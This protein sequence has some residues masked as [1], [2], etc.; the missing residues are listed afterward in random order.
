MFFIV[1]KK[2]LLFIALLCYAVPNMCNETPQEN[3]SIEDFLQAEQKKH[4]LQR[5]PEWLAQQ[6][7]DNA[8]YFLRGILYYLKLGDK[9]AP[10]PS[11]HR[12]ILVGPPGTGK[13]TLANV[14]AYFL[15]SQVYFVPATYF[16]GHFR[17]QTAENI[18][19]FFLKS[20][21]I[22][23]D[24]DKKKVI[25]FDELHKLFEYYQSDK[26][27]AS[28]TAAAFWLMLDYLEKNYPN[29]VVIATMNDAS[30]L[31]PELKSRFHG[32]I[33]TMPLPD[34][35]QKIEA[36]KNS[37]SHDKTVQLAP[38]IDERYISELIAQCENFSLRDV[39]LLIDTAKMFRYADCADKNVKQSLMRSGIV[40]LC[41]ADFQ[42]AVNTLQRE[43]KEHEES[44]F[45]KHYP[46][47]RKLGT[48]TSLA[49]N[50]Y[51]LSKICET[52]I[53]ALPFINFKK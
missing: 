20:D 12:L 43:T 21:T 30:K 38:D 32:K 13:T 42:Q 51:A 16:L 1:R 52:G 34:K 25:I 18:N 31:P 50:V 8:P 4:W 53:R 17:N 11:Y 33:I 29:I 37:I 23:K 7:I 14:I 22:I 36:F 24:A 35:K 15:R 27:D 10:V 46:L 6:C 5:P 44:F 3:V 19:N 2:I 47:M 9:S 28:Q 48:V 39:Q 26:T 40:T 45:E 49:L 41:K